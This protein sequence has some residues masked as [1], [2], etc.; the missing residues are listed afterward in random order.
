MPTLTSPLMALRASGRLMVRIS[1][2][3]RRSRS[4]AAIGAPS[5]RLRPSL[6]GPARP[7][8]PTRPRS[9]V[10][11]GQRRSV[12]GRGARHLDAGRPRGR[13]P[14][15]RPSSSGSAAAA[16]IWRPSA[17]AGRSPG[18]PTPRRRARSPRSP[19]PR[20]PRSV[21]LGRHR[22]GRGVDGTLGRRRCRP[23]A[24]PGAGARR[25]RYRRRAWWRTTPWRSR[26]RC[27][28]A[29]RRRSTMV[30]T[31]VQRVV[32]PGPAEIG[33]AAGDGEA[34]GVVGRRSRAPRRPSRPHTGSTSTG[35]RRRCRRRRVR[36]RPAAAARPL[37]AGPGDD[38]RSGRAEGNQTS[39]ASAPDQQNTARSATPAARAAASE[40]TSDGRALVH[41]RGRRT[42]VSGR[43][44]PP[45]GCRG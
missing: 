22:H 5:S 35:R 7:R 14:P 40:V 44:R 41:V 36:R 31:R 34:P 4:T 3:P 17:R 2:C 10:G 29:R 19:P 28:R 11:L 26:A 30:A 21:G 18:P 9:G 42:C 24:T 43:A 23:G 15:G 32:V 12:P 38:P 16:A 45:G 13:A 27:R 33:K 37:P 25:R 39:V 1:T 20:R 6:T 8:H